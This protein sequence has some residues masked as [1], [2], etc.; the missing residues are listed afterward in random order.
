[1]RK[2][3]YRNDESLTNFSFVVSKND[4]ILPAFR[5]SNKLKYIWRLLLPSNNTAT[6]IFLRL[7]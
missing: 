5:R 3:S 2:V 4:H 7:I 1:M 6:D